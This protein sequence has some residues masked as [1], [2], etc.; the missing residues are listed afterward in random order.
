MAEI[1]E[2]QQLKSRLDNTLADFGIQNIGELIKK[3]Y[4]SSRYDSAPINYIKKLLQ[5]ALPDKVRE[6]IIDKL[7]NE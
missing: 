7:F 6:K 3:Y 4:S 2:P 1:S 5:H